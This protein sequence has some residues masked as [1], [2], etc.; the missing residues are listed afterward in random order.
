MSQQIVFAIFFGKSFRLLL[1]HIYHVPEKQIPIPAVYNFPIL[2]LYFSIYACTHLWHI[3]FLKNTALKSLC[4]HN[5]NSKRAIMENYI[6]M[7][8]EFGS[9]EHG[10][11]KIIEV[12]TIYRK[13]SKW[14]NVTVNSDTITVNKSR[15][16]TRPNYKM[17]DIRWFISSFAYNRCIFY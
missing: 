16:I 14:H 7:E 5:L 6:P 11:Y 10:L 8:S 2:H 15:V 13:N 3:F 12:R 17:V 9:L 4:K 1:I